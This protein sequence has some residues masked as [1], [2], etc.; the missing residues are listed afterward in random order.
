LAKKKCPECPEGAP[1][2]LVSYG[3]MTT[4]LLCFFVF[5]LVTAK[6]D[7]DKLSSASGYMAAKMGL[8]PANTKNNNVIQKKE[9]P[10][11]GLRGDED[12]TL[13]I[14]E[15]KRF[16]LGGVELFKEG[17]ATPYFSTDIQREFLSFARQIR[18]TRNIVEIR[19]HTSAKESEGTIYRDEMDLSTERAR[20][21]L[22]E[23]IEIGKI[24]PDRIRVV[25]CGDHE[26]LKSNLF[27]D[28]EK[29]RR[30]EIRVT[31][32]FQEFNP[33]TVIQ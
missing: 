21:V 9:D 32:K 27:V 11:K 2:W 13:S 20:A 8:L 29:N 5:L 14:D 25:G 26:P 28:K 4:L 31:G 16:I 6:V 15:G 12:Q 3:D 23:L 24:Q 22:K 7:V 10:S 1:D 19:G 17:D 18:G 30:V 33:N